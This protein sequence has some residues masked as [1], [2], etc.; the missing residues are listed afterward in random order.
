[1][2]GKRA[3]GKT[4]AGGK[5][6]RG[7]PVKAQ[8]KALGKTAGKSTGKKSPKARR[9]KPASQGKAQVRWAKERAGPGK[10]N[11][12]RRQK[13]PRPAKSYKSRSE[14]MAAQPPRAPSHLHPT[15]PAVVRYRASS[16]GKFS[17]E[18]LRQYP[19]SRSFVIKK[20]LKSS[21]KDT[22]LE[23]FGSKR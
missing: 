21:M 14:T 11:K 2:S 13:P 9:Q 6:K 8:G 12:V 20:P 5:I 23:L 16:G 19:E 7:V 15:E 22:V 10:A 4:S 1:M 17:F 18:L 3:G